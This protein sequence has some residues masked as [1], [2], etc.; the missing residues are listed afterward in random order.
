MPALKDG[1]QQLCDGSLALR[2]GLS[3]FNE[4]GIS[5]ITE[6]VEGNLEN[7]IERYEAM[8]DLAAGYNTFSGIA[9]GTDGE[10]KFII[11]TEGVEA[12]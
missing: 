9:D 11:R 1:V 10:V 7:V 12:E 2:D 4:K 5:R 6:L 3:E 8:R